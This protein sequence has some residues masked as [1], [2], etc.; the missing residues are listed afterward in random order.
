MVGAN[1]GGGVATV[2]TTVGFSCT[3]YANNSIICMNS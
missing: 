1:N 3:V 2:D